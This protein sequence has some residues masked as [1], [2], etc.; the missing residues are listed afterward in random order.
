MCWLHV[1]STCLPS[2]PGMGDS[3]SGSDSPSPGLAASLTWRGKPMRPRLL[4]AAWKR[5]GWIRLLSGLTLEPSTADRGVASW[6]ASLAATRASRSA[7]PAGGS[8]SPTSGTSGPTSGGSSARSLRS[9]A[10]SRTSATIYEWDSGRSGMTFDRWVI[11]LRR[12]CSRRG[13][14]VRATNA[15]GSSSWPTPRVTT[16]GM[17]ASQ[18]QLERIRNGEQSERGK[19]ACKLEIT[20]ML[21]PTPTSSDQNIF[22]KEPERRTETGRKQQICLNDM[23][24][25]W[26][27]PRASDGEKGGPNMSFGA[28]GTPLPTQ[29]VAFP[30]SRPAPA[31]STPGGRSSGSDLTLNPQFA[32]WLQG[33]PIGW[34]GSGV[35]AT[36]YARWLRLMRSSLSAMRSAIEAEPAQRSMFDLFDSQREA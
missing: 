21:W 20:V 22:G 18:S 27:T 25:L 33:W 10:S 4:S 32:E 9:G 3:N 12:A 36:E 5:G 13:K 30:L 31:T 6:I 34:S 1:P 17:E 23:A 14:S 35:S 16:S 24:Q 15:S 8:V 11:A 19:G 29:V 7:S 2:V 26:A 28:G